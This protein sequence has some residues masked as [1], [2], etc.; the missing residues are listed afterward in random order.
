MTII[1]DVNVP[2]VSQWGLLI[3]ALALLTGVT[4]KAARRRAMQA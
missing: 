2:A 1:D 4:F 3:L